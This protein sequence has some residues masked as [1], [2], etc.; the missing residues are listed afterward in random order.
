MII[1]LKNRKKIYF[2]SFFSWIIFFILF[3]SYHIYIFF[4][5]YSFYEVFTKVDRDWW[6]LIIEVGGLVT[7][8]IVGYY[9][10]GKLPQGENHL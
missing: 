7:V 9:F 4:N 8:A 3:F 2:I 6:E 10:Y 1:G 5:N